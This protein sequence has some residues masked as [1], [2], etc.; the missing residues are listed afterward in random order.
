MAH[1]VTV[2]VAKAAGGVVAGGIGHL[3]VRLRPEGRASR[4][5]AAIENFNVRQQRPSRQVTARVTRLAD[6]PPP[7]RVGLIA[8]LLA[9]RRRAHYSFIRDG[10]PQS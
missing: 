2:T 3:L 4:G 8:S 5:P 10:R 6:R 1:S 9:I 7:I